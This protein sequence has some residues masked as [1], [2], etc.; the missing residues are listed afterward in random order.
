MKA[1]NKKLID[2]IGYLDPCAS[3]MVSRLTL[4]LEGGQRFETKDVTVDNVMLWARE[5]SDPDHWLYIPIE[6][7]LGFEAHISARLL[8]S[9][10]GTTLP[11]IIE[12]CR[13]R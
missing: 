5:E 2:A 1:G 9:E 3:P 13:T 8:T 12:Y 7:V 4:H 6:A 11:N 10:M